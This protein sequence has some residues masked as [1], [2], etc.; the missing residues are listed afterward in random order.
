MRHVLVRKGRVVLGRDVIRQ[1]VV[2]DQ[3]QQPIEQG[4]VDLLVDL[5]Q[6][7]LH[8]DD[9]FALTRLPDVAQV[10][11][12]LTPLVDQER[13]DFRITRLDPAGE[14]VSLIGLV[15]EEGF[16]VG[17]GDL[18]HGLNVVTRDELVVRVKE[19]DTGLLERSLS[20][21]QSLD[22]G[23]RLG[24]MIVGLFNQ[25]QFLSLTLV[26]SSLYRVCSL[27][28]FQRQD[29]K[30]GVVLVGKGREGDRRELS[31][32]KGSDVSCER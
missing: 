10:V 19:L 29:Q 9:T 32:E 25:R 1:V 6:D 23:E 22:S 24:G 5:G 14:Q 16:E 30:L 4:Q 18:F 28:L 13:R 15:P 21:K 31:A 20:Q 7:G 12:P 11:D 8:H 2:H 3:S 27:Q 17:V 26:E